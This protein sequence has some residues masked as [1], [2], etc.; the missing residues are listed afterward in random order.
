MVMKSA[1]LHNLSDSQ[2]RKLSISKVIT[3]NS[4]GLK[5]LI[6]H[7]YDINKKNSNGYPLIYY[8]ATAGYATSVDI[9]IKS[10]VNP[11]QKIKGKLLIDII[12]NKMK[13][14]KVGSY[15]YKKFGK[16]R[17]ILK[18]YDRR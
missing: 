15:F 4:S 14:Y 18:K 16:V 6:K 17:R 8:C 11:N 2:L 10:G 13:K 7:G 5:Y 9:L 3:Y 12:E 1:R